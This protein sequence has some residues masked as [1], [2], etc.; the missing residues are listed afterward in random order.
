MVVDFFKY[1]LETNLDD[2]RM[3]QWSKKAFKDIAVCQNSVLRGG[4]T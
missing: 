4:G 2:P 3:Y 1:H